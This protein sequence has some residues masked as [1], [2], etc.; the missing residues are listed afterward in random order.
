V[1]DLP[2]TDLPRKKRGCFAALS[3]L[4]GLLLLGAIAIW[5]VLPIGARNGLMPGTARQTVENADHFEIISLDPYRTHEGNNR[6]HGYLIRGRNEL[7]DANAR[8]QLLNA[9]YNSLG[10]GVPGIMCFNPRHAIHAVLDGHTVDLLI[11]FEC[12][13]V[14]GFVDGHRTDALVGFGAKTEF[15]RIF[16]E[17]GLPAA[18]E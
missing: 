11:C 12:Q 15:E 5:F 18:M 6:F 7:H 14:E 3:R 8:K 17:A 13:Q 9:L 2:P 10:H 1:S 4:V 16:R